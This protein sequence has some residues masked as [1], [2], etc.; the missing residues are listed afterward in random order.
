MNDERKSYPGLDHFR[1]L[2]QGGRHRQAVG[3][4]WDQLG[5]LQLEFLKTQG[6]SPNHKLI[7]IGCGALRAGVKLAPYLDRG[8]YF[9]VDSSPDLVEAGYDKEIAAA[10]LKSRLPRENLRINADFDLSGF[11]T[12][13]DFGIAQSLFT[14]LPFPSLKTCLERIAPYFPEGALFFAT[15]FEAPEDFAEPTRHQGGVVSYPDANPFHYRVADIE[16]MAAALP[17]RFDYIGAWD[18]PRDQRMLKFE[19]Q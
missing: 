13:F 4:L 19:K 9:G 16:D 8:N 6:L 17:W 3:G 2:A 14:H 7:D 15:I 10:G 18:H 1:R 11:Q 5:A 12:R